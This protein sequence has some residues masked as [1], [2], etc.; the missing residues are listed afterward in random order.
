M[1]NNLELIRS[2]VG[3]SI[4]QDDLKFI[5]CYTSEKLAMFLPLGGNCGY[6][7]T[8]DHTHPSYMFVLS[9]D[10]ETVVHVGERSFQASPK[11]MFCLAPEVSHHE[12][13][14][15]FPPRYCAIFIEKRF[16]EKML[17]FYEKELSLEN[18][19]AL[20]LESTKID[21]LTKEFM[22]ESSHKH[23]S[24]QMVQESIVNLLT[25]EI[26][27]SI[28]DESFHNN[29]FVSESKI[30]TEVVKYINANYSQEVHLEGISKAV[31]VSASH[32]SNIFKDEMGVSVME[33]LKT[34][35]LEN[36][37]KM[38]L[39][40]TLSVTEVARQCGFNSPS[41]FS[42]LFRQRYHVRPRECMNKQ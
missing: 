35:R 17:A 23:S 13:K 20:K 25:H 7:V 22:L 5:E 24:S 21:M 29:E 28:L 15:Y 14:N 42:K 27:R 39:S 19:L 10:H 33:Y 2:L 12:Q 40:R 37:K 3:S 32:I 4:T 38:L 41:Y 8:P 1:Q 11:S 9:Y 34:L 30:I 26:I 36:A 31:G 16:F 6:A 18:G